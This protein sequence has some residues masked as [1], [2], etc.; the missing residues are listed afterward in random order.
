M[1]ILGIEFRA[2]VLLGWFDSAVSYIAVRWQPSL[3]IVLLALVLYWAGGWIL[4]IVQR[5]FA[6]K[7]ETTIDDEFVRFIRKALRL[8][9]VALA[10]WLLMGMWVPDLGEETRDG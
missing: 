7:T 8:T 10:L 9:L 1:E 4:R 5:R 2:D 6:A 3:A